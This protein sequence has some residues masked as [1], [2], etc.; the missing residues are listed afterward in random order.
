MH[1]FL[2]ISHWPVDTEKPRR[3]RGARRRSG[4]YPIESPSGDPVVTAARKAL[5]E[6]GWTYRTAGR[7]L[8]ISYVHLAWVLTGRRESRRL[9]AAIQALPPRD[10][11]D[12]A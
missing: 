3:K 4:R 2:I 10:R 6:K 11:A 9:L 8:G 1:D 5:A 12:A 7:A